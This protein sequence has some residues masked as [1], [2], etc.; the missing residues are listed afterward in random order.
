[1]ILSQSI[2]VDQHD[3]IP[4]L[5]AGDACRVL[6]NDLRRNGNQEFQCHRVFLLETARLKRRFSHIPSDLVVECVTA[7]RKPPDVRTWRLSNQSCVG[8]LPPSTSTPHWPA[9]LAR[10]W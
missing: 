1:M 5:S 9:C 4:A 8:T 2:Q 10:H 3:S 6:L 7:H